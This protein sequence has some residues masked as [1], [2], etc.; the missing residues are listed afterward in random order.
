MLSVEGGAP[1]PPGH[2]DGRDP[3]VRSFVAAQAS[4]ELPAIRILAA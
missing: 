3:G 2:G 4:R 1:T